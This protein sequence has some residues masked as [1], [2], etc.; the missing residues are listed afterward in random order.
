MDEKRVTFR[1]GELTLEGLLAIPAGS[2]EAGA[3]VICHPHPL[4]GGSMH[5]NV[6]EAILE[7]LWLLG[8]ATLRFNFRGVGASEG[9]Y[10]EGQGESRDALAAVAFAA[11]NAGV[12]AGGVTLAGYSFGAMVAMRA[13]LTASE[14][15]R[16][17]AVAL[18]VAMAGLSSLG[19]ASKPV[20]LVSGDRDS[21]SP[22]D[23]V[24]ALGARL[25]SLATARI[26]AGADHFFGGFEGELS[27]VIARALGARV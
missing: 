6:V 25:G 19:V 4:Y 23:A 14:V 3:A 27:S 2:A 21:Y 18:P 12:R 20:L 24:R 17:I 11:A 22:A 10:D 26:I 7:A 13:G 15:N 9:A 1:S 16:V 8:C 5:N